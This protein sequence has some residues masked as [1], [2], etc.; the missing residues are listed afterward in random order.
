MQGKGFEHVEY[1]SVYIEI[2]INIFF[3][4]ITSVKS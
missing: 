1:K 2:K 4:N 3:R